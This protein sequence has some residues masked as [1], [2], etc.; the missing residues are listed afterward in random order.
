MYR[1][2]KTS[3]SLEKAGCNHYKLIIFEYIQDIFLM[4]LRWGGLLYDQ[5]S[6]RTWLFQASMDMILKL[7]A[8]F[9]I[10]K[11]RLWCKRSFSILSTWKN[12]KMVIT[13]N[14]IG[15]IF[16]NS[17][18]F[19]NLKKEF[20][21]TYTQY[22]ITYCLSFKLIWSFKWSEN[23]TMCAKLRYYYLFRN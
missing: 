12:R 4:K 14:I 16:Y 1:I 19:N 11:K 10:T 22:N 18:I 6:H 17:S 8:T 2:S 21:S 3:V 7:L 9:A 13:H 20:C 15:C 23:P 5:V